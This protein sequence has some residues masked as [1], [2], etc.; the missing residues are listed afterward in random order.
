MGPLRGAMDLVNADHPNLAAKL[1]QVLNKEPLWRYIED[2]N[3]LLLDRSEHFLL[4]LV[5][6]SRVNKSSWHEVWKLHKLVLHQS[7]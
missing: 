5:G 6:Q 1:A 2:F 4:A 7:N 3:F